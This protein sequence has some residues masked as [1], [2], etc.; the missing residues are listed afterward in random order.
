MESDGPNQD[1]RPATFLSRRNGKYVAIN[2]VTKFV[3]VWDLDDGR[4]T[5]RLA[6]PDAT[7]T[8]DFLQ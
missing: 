4:E 5:F 7:M 2:G 3:P 6:L 8:S 1:P